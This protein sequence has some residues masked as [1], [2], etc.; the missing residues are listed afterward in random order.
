[1]PLPEPKPG[2][3]IRYDYVWER[4]TRI[5]GKERPACLVATIDDELDP[6]L[7]LLLPITHSPPVGETVG[8]EIPLKVA[9]RLRL[10]EKRSWIIVSEA[11]IDHWPN[12][13][14]APIPGKPRA[15]AYGFLPPEFFEQIRSRFFKLLAERKPKMVRR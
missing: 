7:V 11:N 9:E 13:G 1:M 4:E 14:L 3:V 5:A 6:R 15:F 8:V 2:L 10:D 12:A